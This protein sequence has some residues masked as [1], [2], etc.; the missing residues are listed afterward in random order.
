M[1]MSDDEDTSHSVLLT[2]FHIQDLGGKQFLTLRHFNSK[3]TTV[4]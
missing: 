1:E 4:R 3:A 2:V